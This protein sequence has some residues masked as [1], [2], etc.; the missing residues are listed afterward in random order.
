MLVVLNLAIGLIFIYLLFSPVVSAFN[1]FWLSSLD[2]RADFLK[3]A[4]QQLLQDP[5]KVEQ[6]LAHGRVDALSRRT[7]GNPT[8][9]AQK[10]LLGLSLVLAA[11]FNVDTIHIIQAL[12]TNSKLLATTVDQAVTTAN[13]QPSQPSTAST[14]DTTNM[15]GQ[16]VGK[17]TSAISNLNNTS[18]PV[19]W[20]KSQREYLCDHGSLCTAL[21]GWALTGLAAS[22]GAPLWFDTLQCFVNIRSNGRSPDEKDIGTKNNHRRKMQ[23]R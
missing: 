4:L 14:E 21:L 5:T 7:N 1:E 13:S 3:E 15:I 10:W 16:L 8:Y 23:S 12:S 2:K 19:R 17:A 9:Y 20:H 6:V 11:A 22:L 18:V